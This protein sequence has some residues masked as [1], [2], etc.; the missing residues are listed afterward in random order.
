MNKKNMTSNSGKR[1][2]E[3]G[4]TASAGS[5]QAAGGEPYQIAGGEHPALTTNQ[6]VANVGIDAG[7]VDASDKTASIAAAKNRQ[8]DRDKLVRTL[9]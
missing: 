9:A 5:Q 8:W 2:Q 1:R 7:V 3:K 6:G 4:S